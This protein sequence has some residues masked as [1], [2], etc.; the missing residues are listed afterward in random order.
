MVLVLK[1]REIKF[2]LEIK[3]YVGPINYNC[4]RFDELYFSG[5]QMVRFTNN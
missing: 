2:D 1:A 5:I 3:K 4:L